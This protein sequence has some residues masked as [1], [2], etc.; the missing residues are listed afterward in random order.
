MSVGHCMG[1]A[2]EIGRLP[3]GEWAEAIRQIPDGCEQPD[4]GAPKSCRMRVADF[5]R[6]QWLIAERRS[7]RGAAA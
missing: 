6:V 3:R 4:C 1:R 2:L 7:K 5:L